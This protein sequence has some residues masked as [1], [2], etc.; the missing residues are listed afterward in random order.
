MRICSSTWRMRAYRL[1]EYSRLWWQLQAVAGTWHFHRLV[2]L[3]PRR[4]AQRAVPLKSRS[5]WPDPAPFP[6]L[7]PSVYQFT[8][9]NI[10]AR[11]WNACIACPLFSPSHHGE[12]NSNPQG[13]EWG[14]KSMISMFNDLRLRG[15]KRIISQESSVPQF[16]QG[17]HPLNRTWP[18]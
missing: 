14:I 8:A 6:C 10:I 12:M 16:P 15:L 2:N 13:L 11:T 9:R 3:W 1:G 18:P 4:S 17:P 7:D 5:S